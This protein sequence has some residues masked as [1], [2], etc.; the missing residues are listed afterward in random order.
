MALITELKQITKDRQAVHGLVEC[1]Y[2][3]FTGPD[4]Q[5][6]LQLETFGSKERQIPGKTSQAIQLSESSA[7]ELK[8]LIEETFPS[9]R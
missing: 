8:R 7:T 1:A 2:S 6:Y 9:L 5:R 4:G 3:V